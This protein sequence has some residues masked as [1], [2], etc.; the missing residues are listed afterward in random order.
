MPAP[1]PHG[2]TRPQASPT[3]SRLGR[4]AVHVYS[5][6]P[7]L[8]ELP[9][10]QAS[11]GPNEQAWLERLLAMLDAW[12]VP[13]PARAFLVTALYA[14]IRAT[15][16]TAAAYQRIDDHGIRAWRARATTTALLIPDVAECYPQT[17]RLQPS[18]DH[19]AA[20]SPASRSE[21]P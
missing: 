2:A 19:M 10:S 5:A 4:L 21:A 18:S 13:P 6:H 20:G 9:W 12:H 14:T 11:Q 15:A 1:S 17:M 3:H 8:T 16:Q 7:W